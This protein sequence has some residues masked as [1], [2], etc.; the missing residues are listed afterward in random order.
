METFIYI[1]LGI[2]TA[3]AISLN[4]S[5]KTKEDNAFEEATEVAIEKVTGF[6]VDLSPGSDEAN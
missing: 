6:D 5:G 1:A 3:V 2:A 4:V